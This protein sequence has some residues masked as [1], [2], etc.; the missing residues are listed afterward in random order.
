MKLLHVLTAEM[1]EKEYKSHVDR[2]RLWKKPTI[3]I[4]PTT[5]SSSSTEK[6]VDRI[7]KKK[8]QKHSEQKRRGLFVTLMVEDFGGHTS[9]RVWKTIAT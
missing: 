9:E 7:P 3:K 2:N 6:S 4:E 8:N 5:L 1:L